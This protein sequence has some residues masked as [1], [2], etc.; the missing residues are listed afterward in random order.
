MN[1][2]KRFLNEF[3]ESPGAFQFVAKRFVFFSVKLCEL[4]FSVL[5]KMEI[6]FS[7]QRH[8]VLRA[9]QS[10]KCMRQFEMHPNRRSQL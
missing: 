6:Q 2:L 3:E 9:T 7:A 10:L 8:K 5:K 1:L 4:C